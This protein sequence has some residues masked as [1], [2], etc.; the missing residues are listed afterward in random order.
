LP[1]RRVFLP[2]HSDMSS[3]LL[4]Q[5]HRSLHPEVKQLAP[6]LQVVRRSV[7]T[8]RRLG[9]R[10]K[11]AVSHPLPNLNLVDCLSFCLICSPS[12]IARRPL[13]CHSSCLAISAPFRSSENRGVGEKRVGFSQQRCFLSPLKLS[14][15]TSTATL[16]NPTYLLPVRAHSTPLKMLH[17]SEVA[18]HNK[19][20]DLWVIVNGNA[21]DLSDVSLPFPSPLVL[22]TSKE[23]NETGTDCPFPRSVSFEAP[24]QTAEKTMY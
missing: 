21:Y 7:R 11:V 15:S 8:R 18:K 6:I 22:S 5:T 20:G 1:P 10:R 3:P 4:S 16:Y 19:A 17:H 9:G 12:Y 13:C 24:R 2:L 14:P 23:A